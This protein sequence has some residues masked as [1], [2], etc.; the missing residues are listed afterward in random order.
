[1]VDVVELHLVRDGLAIDLRLRATG[2]SAPFRP[3]DGRWRPAQ[4]QGFGGG[5]E[6][7]GE[8]L[9]EGVSCHV[10]RGEIFGVLE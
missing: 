6:R 4:Q 2:P 1:V 5:I 8:R 3:P 10:D 7:P 9:G